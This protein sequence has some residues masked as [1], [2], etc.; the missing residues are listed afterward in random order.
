M[1]PFRQQDSPLTCIGCACESPLIESF[2][3]ER[4][5]DGTLL[6]RRKCTDGLYGQMRCGCH[7]ENQTLCAD[8]N[9][10]LEEVER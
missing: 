4:A 2:H 10:A 6:L 8:C 3:E 5:E 1:H 7:V 9:A